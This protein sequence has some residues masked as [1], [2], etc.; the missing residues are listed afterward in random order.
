MFQMLAQSAGDTVGVKAVG[1]LTDDDYKEFLP[2]LEKVIDEHRR[3]R[4]LVDMED[5]EGWEPRAAW[6][7]FAF[8]MTHWNHFAKIALVGDAKCEVLAA[9]TMNI[10]MRGETRFFEL[11]EAE[12]AWE[13][14]K[15]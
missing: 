15:N 9:K 1:V 7:D 2:K 11:D 3:V 12:A 10:L 8:G 14:V 6:D 13:W 4:L 5:F